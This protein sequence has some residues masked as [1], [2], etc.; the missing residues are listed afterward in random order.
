MIRGYRGSQTGLLGRA[1]SMPA[2]A[3]ITHAISLQAR[4]ADEPFE[5]EVRHG[6]AARTSGDVQPGETI[7]DAE[8]RFADLVALG[9]VAGEQPDA[10]Q[11]YV[12]LGVK[13]PHCGWIPDG[14]AHW[15]CDA[16][17]ADPF[18]TFEAGGECPACHEVFDDTL[19]PRCQHLSPYEW[20]WP[21]ES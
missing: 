20:W 15:G 19:C 13:C 9:L 12:K 2:I 4:S 8:E 7:F 16:C 6:G 1:L 10:A 5:G 18:N 11:R 21:A 3:D 17:S 14:E